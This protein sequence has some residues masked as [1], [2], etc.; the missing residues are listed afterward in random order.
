MVNRI[1]SALFTALVCVSAT[2]ETPTLHRSNNMQIPLLRLKMVLDAFNSDDIAIGFYPGATMQ[3]N[4]QLDSRYMPGIDALEGLSSLSSDNVQLSVNIMPL[5]AL[6]P[7]IIRLDVE[8]AGSNS[9]TLERTQLDSIPQIFDIWLMDKYAKDSVNLR[10]TNSYPFSINKNDTTTFGANRFTVVIRQ[11]QAL[12]FRLTGF[13]GRKETIGNELTWTTQNEQ[14]N[15][16]FLVERSI[17][18]GATFFA[19]DSLS[20]NGSGLYN[21]LD[22]SPLDGA[23]LYRLKTT[24][25]N[26]TVTWSNIVTID[27]R[28]A[29]AAQVGNAVNIYPNPSNGFIT[30]VINSAGG[31]VLSDSH[32]QLS[33]VQQS[34]TASKPNNALTYD[35]KIVNIRGVTVRS[36]ISSSATWQDNVSNLV[37]GTYFIQVISKRDNKVVGK[38]TFVKL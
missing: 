31:D 9:F 36:A 25:M 17:D 35:I 10:T 38:S 23:N 14:N 8:A 24:D 7:L 1:L 15:T 37:P 2:A 32:L 27:S 18:E 19:L 28:K 34:F 3:Y 4:N 29:A 12:T 5:P 26:G 6:T 16:G 11:S 21:F 33:T 20:S 22:K 13:N 30:L